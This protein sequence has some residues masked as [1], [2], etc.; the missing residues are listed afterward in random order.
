MVSAAVCFL[1]R[2]TSARNIHISFLSYSPEAFVV[3]FTSEHLSAYLSICPSPSEIVLSF[4]PTDVLMTPAKRYRPSRLYN[5]HPH[6][7]Q[8]A[9]E[10]PR[11]I[12]SLLSRNADRPRELVR[13]LYTKSW[14]AFD[15]L[16]SVIPP[17]GSIG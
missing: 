12:A 8:S 11:Y 14:S 16:V 17:G 3:P 6:P 4:G 15:R 2:D 9:H 5:L 10:K 7:A 13:D 1:P